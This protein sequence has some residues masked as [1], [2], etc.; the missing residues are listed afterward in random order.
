MS[1]YLASNKVVV[2]ASED[3]PPNPGEVYDAVEALL[4][5]ETADVTY[6]DTVDPSIEKD[7]D[8]VGHDVVRGSSDGTVSTVIKN[9]AEV[10]MEFRLRAIP[11]AGTP[12]GY[13][14]ILKGANLAEEVVADDVVYTRAT[15]NPPAFTIYIYERA[16]HTDNWR[17]EVATG[18]RGNLSFTAEENSEVTMSFEGRGNFHEISDGA[19]FI[20]VES[21]EIALLK[22]GETAVAARTTGEFVQED[23][24]PMPARDITLQ[25]DEV[26]YGVRQFEFDL[27]HDSDDVPTI[28]GGATRSSGTVTRAGEAR[29]EGSIEMTDYTEAIIDDVRDKA[30]SDCDQFEFFAAFENGEGRVELSGPR[31]QFL[32]WE[33]TTN[34]N[35]RQFDIPFVLNGTHDLVSDDEL[36]ITFMPPEV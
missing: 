20:D 14:P 8:A 30:Y 29:T 4:Q 31:A 33:K 36:T 32:P 26:D 27:Q 6:I 7:T 16:A 25:F 24:C 15:K 1:I 18:V 17:L 35:N 3:D 28:S 23:Q 12:P 34:G 13:G 19:E 11:G 10:T 5:D 9:A 21:G 2:V 22:D